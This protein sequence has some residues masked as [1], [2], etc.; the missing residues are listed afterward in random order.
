[1]NNFKRRM[2][3]SEPQI[4]LQRQGEKGWELYKV[5]AGRV[6]YS[7]FTVD[8]SVKAVATVRPGPSS[9]MLRFSQNAVVW[10]NGLKPNGMTALNVG[11]ARP[12][13]TGAELADKVDVFRISMAPLLVTALRSEGYPQ[14]AV[15]NL[16]AIT[17]TDEIFI[18]DRRE[19]DVKGWIVPREWYEESLYPLQ[20][21]G[22]SEE[23]ELEDIVVEYDTGSR[24]VSKIWNQ[25]TSDE[26]SEFL[27]GE[28]Q[29]TLKVGSRI[30]HIFWQY[31]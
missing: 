8:D 9:T 4:L 6:L 22:E 2:G 28:T 30:P 23:L 10:V 12:F 13:P 26:Y 20:S 7:V 17:F 18:D 1:M 5:E 16:R 24:V 3:D 21:S 11:F 29:A 19:N 15:G 27:D 14:L 25:R 31:L